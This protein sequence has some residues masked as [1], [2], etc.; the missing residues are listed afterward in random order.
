MKNLKL[1][2]TVNWSFLLFMLAIGCNPSRTDNKEQKKS[3]LILESDI[4]LGGFLPLSPLNNNI[5]DMTDR[6]VIIEDFDIPGFPKK[7]ITYGTVFTIMAEVTDEFVYE[8]AQTFHEMFPQDPDLDLEMQKKV[9][10]NML[11]YGS[12]IPVLNGR[13]ESLSDDMEGSMEQLSKDYSVCDI[14]MYRDG[15]GRQTMEVVEHLLHYL[16]S[17][18]LHLTLPKDW[19]FSDPKS[20]VIQV[21]NQAIEVGLYDVES[22]KEMNEEDKDAYQRIIVQEFSY[23]LISSY[24]DLQEPYG[25][26][27]EKEWNINNKQDLLKKLPEGYDLVEQ[28]VDKFMK[29]PSLEILETFKKYN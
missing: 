23:W 17:I 22:Y 27:S 3:D 7:M 26:I 25:P 21:M 14:I 29:S 13:Y 28:T 24:W 1:H 19:S 12:L 6:S 10:N 20:K 16:T 18:G 9:L 8:V 15:T 2:K 4:R 11:Q 5:V